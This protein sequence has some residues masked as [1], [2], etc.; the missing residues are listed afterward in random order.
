MVFN[1]VREL[2]VP[3]RFKMLDLAAFPMRLASFELICEIIRMVRADCLMS[4]GS[5][6]KPL[7]ESCIMSFGPV[8]QDVDIQ[9]NE[10]AIASASEFGIPS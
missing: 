9:T 4:P 6:K 7:I 3:Q 1:T 8:L 2:S 5:T 10:Q